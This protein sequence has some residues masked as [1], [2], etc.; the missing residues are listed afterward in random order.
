[1]DDP[2]D[3]EIKV[4]KMVRILN[5]ETKYGLNSNMLYRAQIRQT[6]LGEVF[7]VDDVQEAPGE[8]SCHRQS[9]WRIRR[10]GEKVE[11]HSIAKFITRN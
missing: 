2:G 11:I 7:L 5:S 8:S 3:P 6:K 4:S 1:M 9:M 10:N